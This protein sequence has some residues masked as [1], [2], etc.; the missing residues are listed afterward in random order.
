M[1]DISV[2]WIGNN[3]TAFKAALQCYKLQWMDS[4]RSV[5]Q[6]NYF[7]SQ[8]AGYTFTPG[9]GHWPADPALAP[10]WQVGWGRA[11]RA[12]SSGERISSE[13]V[14]MPDGSRAP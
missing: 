5:L 8:Q 10:A 4:S 9:A 3:G 11:G 1:A 12:G 6:T 13:C 2:V 14:L 7:T